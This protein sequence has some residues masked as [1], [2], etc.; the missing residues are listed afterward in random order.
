MWYFYIL[1]C[2]DGT[3]YSGISNNLEH[4]YKMH[5]SGKGAKYTRSRRPVKLIYFESFR[6]R[7]RVM[8]REWEVKTFSRKKK[9]SLIKTKNV[10]QI[11]RALI[12]KNG[13]LLVAHEKGAANTFLPGGHIEAGESPEEA[14]KRELYEELKLLPAPGVFK[15]ILHHSYTDNRIRKHEVNYLCRAELPGDC[16]VSHEEH[17]EFFL[18]KATKKELKKC[19]LK[20]PGLR[21]IAAA[22]CKKG[23][24]N[25]NEKQ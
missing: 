23:R 9:E 13:F 15:E 24:K 19:N 22:A 20:P 16:F 2:A 4:R 1:K 12:F 3:L 25:S 17:L 21:A 14:L 8:R 5:N 6:S 7:L 10:E 18:V 11:A